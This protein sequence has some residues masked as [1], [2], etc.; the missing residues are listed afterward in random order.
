MDEQDLRKELQQATAA[1]RVAWEQVRNKHPGTPGHDP[2]LWST[3]LDT[4]RRAVEV[5]RALDRMLKP[6]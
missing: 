2:K 1:E 4:E 3:W 5:K 6:S